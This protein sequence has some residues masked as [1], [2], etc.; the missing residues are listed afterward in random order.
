M[1]LALN[2]VLETVSGPEPVFQAA[3]SVG[4]LTLVFPVRGFT[5]WP[6]SVVRCGAVLGLAVVAV[7]L[8]LAAVSL[9]EGLCAGAVTGLACGAAWREFT[10]IRDRSTA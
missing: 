7:D 6:V 2:L 3:I 5:S 1:V 10:A 8:T 4:L 9:G